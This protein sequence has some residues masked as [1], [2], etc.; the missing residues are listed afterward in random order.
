MRWEHC[1]KSTWEASA[2]YYE[3]QRPGSEE[4]A[5]AMVAEGLVDIIAT[6]HHGP[7]RAGVSPL[8]ALRGAAGS[9]RSRALAERA[10]VERP[11]T[12]LRDEPM[13]DPGEAVSSPR[14]SA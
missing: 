10:M 8:E 1:C 4:L 11:A 12:M 6:D 3:G 5:W 2:G 9:R 13:A 14:A 7:R